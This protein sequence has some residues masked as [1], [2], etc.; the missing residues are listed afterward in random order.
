MTL[1]TI[2]ADSRMS[3]RRVHDRDSSLTAAVR[4]AAYRVYS[5][6]LAS[7]HE[8]DVD[9]QLRQDAA[10][11]ALRPYGIDLGA[12]CDT[13]LKTDIALRKREYSAL[14]EVGEAGTLIPIREQQQYQDT[15]GVLEDVVR[16]YDFF[17]YTLSE[18]YAWAPD[19]MSV[20]LEF[21]YVLCHRESVETDN[22]LSYQLAQY[23]FIS[24]HL[25]PWSQVLADRVAEV[26]PS[27]LYAGIARSLSAFVASDVAWQGTTISEGD[28]NH[29]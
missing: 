6:L 18:K 7:P 11:S 26:R 16:F 25:V 3:E 27:A 10:I 21:C 23:D 17:D 4:G 19:H 24:R 29:A 1:G 20:I 8:V 12:L 5:L 13:Y 2:P 22:R 9:Q 14:F 28:T 15:A